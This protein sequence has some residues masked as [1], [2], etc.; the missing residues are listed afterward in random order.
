M[1]SFRTGSLQDDLQKDAA[2]DVLLGLGI[3]HAEIHVLENQL[4]HVFQGDIAADFRV[5]ETAVRI[6]LDDA[7]LAH[8]AA[9]RWDG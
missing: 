7:C 6:L 2:G 4:T 9:P 5:V 8:E 3:L 1:I